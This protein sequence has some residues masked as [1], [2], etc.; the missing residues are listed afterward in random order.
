M[1]LSPQLFL[2]PSANNR[3]GPNIRAPLICPSLLSAKWVTAWG[4]RL[5]PLLCVCV[6]PCWVEGALRDWKRGASTSDRRRSGAGQFRSAE[7]STG[8]TVAVRQPAGGKHTLTNP[9]GCLRN[10]DIPPL[11]LFFSG[12][13]LAFSFF[14]LLSW[15]E[16]F[17]SLISCWKSEPTLPWT[18]LAVMDTH[19]RW[20]V[21]RR[22]RDV[23]ITLSV[24]LLFITS[25]AS[26][27]EMQL[28]GAFFFL[29]LWM[30]FGGALHWKVFCLFAHSGPQMSAPPL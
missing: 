3:A 28:C 22:I 12:T 11:P 27:G 20:K 9:Y 10:N 7:R 4:G 18:S 1:K 23:Q 8:E 30:H 15:P 21:K 17:A 6:L 13:F 19:I 24:I 16:V 26:S 2:P 25:Q 5:L 14:F 29:F